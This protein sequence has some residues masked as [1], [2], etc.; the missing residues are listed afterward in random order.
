MSREMKDSGIEWIGEIPIDWEIIKV[1]SRYKMVTGF[2]PDTD[3]SLY[4]DDENGYTWINISDL[5][6]EREIFD[7]KNK[8]TK[9]A[10]EKCKGNL[11]NKGSLLFSFKLSV[12]QVAF[13]GTDLYT[14]EAI[15][16][17]LKT[18]NVNLDFFYYMSQF[19]IIHN[20]IENIYGA[21]LLNQFL[22]RNA[23][24]LFPPL[25]EQQAIADYLDQKVSEIDKIISQTALSIEE[26]KRYKQSLIT[27][28]VTKGLNPEVEMK[29]SGI[30]WIGEIPNDWTVRKLKANVLTTKGCAFKLDIFSAE[31]VSVVKA[32][33]MK[34]GTILKGDT[35]IPIELA[36]Q[37]L[38]V[39]LETN[40]IL[41]TTVGSTPNVVNS[42]VGQI[43]KVPTEANDS[44]LNQNVVRIRP[45]SNINNEY[46]FYYLITHAFR[47]YLDLNSHGTANQASLTLKDI[48]DYCITLPSIKQQ[49]EI[50]NYLN[51]K[52]SYVDNLIQQKQ[53]LVAELQTYKKSLIYECVTGK[54]E[55]V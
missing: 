14:N 48:L 25:P 45:N 29:D 11:I 15:A 20:A 38:S 36:G 9:L 3:E 1:K 41:M 42:A 6:S 7:S 27:E 26:Y 51:T 53:G 43:A 32:S 40:D 30:E 39:K 2:T 13:A 19:A 10:T 33:D 17:F 52:C 23:T 12:G 21:K 22:I 5:S 18:E 49:K 35:Y 31:G 24:V 28:A 47:K 37:F 54:R 8:I 16:S 55:V 50:I 4:Y 44:L 34:N 46:L